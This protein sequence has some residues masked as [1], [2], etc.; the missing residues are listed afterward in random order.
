V[1]GGQASEGRP[2]AGRGQARCTVYA[3][4]APWVRCMGTVPGEGHAVPSLSSTVLW[5]KKT[6]LAYPFAPAALTQRTK[7]TLHG[8]ACEQVQVS[9]SCHL[10]PALDPPLAAAAFFPAAP[11]A[12]PHLS[13]GPLKVTSSRSSVLKVGLAGSA[14]CHTHTQ[15]SKPG[16]SVS[17]RGS[18]PYA[19]EEAATGGGRGHATAA[20]TAEAILQQLRSNAQQQAATVYPPTHSPTDPPCPGSP[21][22]AAPGPWHPPRQPPRCSC[23]TRR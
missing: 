5:C 20:R 11:P 13:V 14:V 3:A 4:C 7:V 9:A 10:Q 8:S 12:G 23:A 18:R 6:L 15:T 1:A 19:A 16:P 17:S 2:Q 22:P 21:A